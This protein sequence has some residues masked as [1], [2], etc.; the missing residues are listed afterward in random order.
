L[1]NTRKKERG[2]SGGRPADKGDE[3]YEKG[4]WWLA[5]KRNAQRREEEVRLR[6][7]GAGRRKGREGEKG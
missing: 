3:N 2:G 5:G 1:K 4:S 7:K 6:W